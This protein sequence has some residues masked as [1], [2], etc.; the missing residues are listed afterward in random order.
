MNRF[1]RHQRLGDVAAILL[2]YF[3]GVGFQW[4]Y[5]DRN[6][7]LRS[8]VPTSLSRRGPNAT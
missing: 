2:E 5:D 1:R 3:G 4:P 7:G 6:V 8:N